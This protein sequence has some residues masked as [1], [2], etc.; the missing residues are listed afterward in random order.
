MEVI[1]IKDLRG[2]G[3]KGDIKEVKTGYAQNFL[4]KNGYEF[5]SDTDKEVSIIKDYCDTHNCDFA[6]SEVWEHG[7]EGG[8]ELAK[9][10][11]NTLETKDSNF[12]VLYDTELTIKEKIEI[13]ASK[14]YGA[15]LVTYDVSV[16]KTIKN[17]EKLGYDKLP[18]C[19]AKNQYSL[20][21]DPTKLG[22]PTDFSINIRDLYVS[23]GA[24]FIVAITGTVMTMPGLPKKPAAELIDVSEDGLI[25]GLF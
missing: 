14:I 25:T 18:I 1:F 13:I 17:L 21:D 22:R 12:K 3:K 19:M 15:S 4:I 6:L 23:A 2:Q 20:S 10:V 11:L 16:E 5:I 24:G 7:G 9:A 8:I